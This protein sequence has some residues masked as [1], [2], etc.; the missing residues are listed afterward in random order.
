VRVRAAVLALV[1]FAAAGCESKKSAVAHPDSLRKLTQLTEERNDFGVI[2]DAKSG[3]ALAAFRV[4]NPIRAAVA[5]GDGGWYVGGGFI[6]VDGV[7]RKRLAHIRSDGTL[8]LDW[9]PEANGN[10]VSVTALA[11]LGSRL[12]VA[13]D[14]ALLQHEPRLHLGALDVKTGRLD[15]RWRPANNAPLAAPALLAARSR[16]IVGGGSCCS[17]AGS[18]VI[19]LGAGSGRLDR[20]WR[21]HVGAV[22]L[23][24]DGVY[25]LASN[26]HGVLIRGLL[27]RP[28]GAVA[29]GELDPSSGELARKWSFG[30]ARNCEWCALMAAAVGNDRVYASVNGS[31]RFPV[32]AFDRRNG[33][34]DPSWH[35]R[36]GSATG[37]YGATSALAIATTPSRVY[38]AGDFETIGGRARRGIAAI[39]PQTARLLPSWNP[40]ANRAYASVLSSS[41]SRLL[42]GLEL[43]P[44]VQFEFTGLKTYVPVRRLN[45]VLGLSGP[46]SVRIGLGR[47]CNFE[48]WAETG[49]CSGHVFRWLG[50]VRFSSPGR[51]RYENALAGVRPGRY[52][53]RFVPHGSDGEAETPSDFPIKVPPPEVRSTSG[54]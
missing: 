35:V 4:D 3:R 50:S 5:D 33:R 20:S 18:A 23:Y 47:R 32:I 7:L 19:A 13:G 45:L 15:R 22:P 30:S 21:P 2:L 29:V 16:L 1:A 10:G 52:F 27:G 34:L 41:G 8:D 48:N 31:A 53:V 38:L 6:H 36:I 54:G 9:R 49:R 28:L 24:G 40:R 25:L 17:E 44:Q 26:G 12:F 39:D 14:F 51:R 43:S 37:F 46:G 11:R 42:V